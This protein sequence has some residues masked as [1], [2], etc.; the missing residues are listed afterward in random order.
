MNYIS[1]QFFKTPYGELVL[2]SYDAK[3]CMCDWRYRKTRTAIDNR[4]KNGL[5]AS[6]VEENSEVLNSTKEQLNEYFDYKRKCFDIPLLMIGTEFQ[7]NVWNALI[8]I[9]FATTASY[10]ELAQQID[11][12][13]AVRAVAN[14]NG[15]NA[16]SI[17]IPCHRIV[18]SR[19]ELTGYAG[20]LS[21]KKKLL[22]LEQ[23]LFSL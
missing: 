12:K 19:G 10:A 18:G 2:G 8:K 5:D 22:E 13:K 17:F 14:A 9:P 21:T 20:G 15:A 7:K 1:I 23:S 6:F 3:L 16:I 4:L 11:N